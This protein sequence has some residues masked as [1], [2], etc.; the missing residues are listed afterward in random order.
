MGNGSHRA[1]AIKEDFH[2]NDLKLKIQRV[3]SMKSGHTQD[4]KPKT[5][6]RRIKYS[7][8]LAVDDTELLKA[9]RSQEDLG[10]S[11]GKSVANV[12]K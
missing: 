3:D 6:E 5:S 12:R 7:G 1:S 8:K 2:D 4:S 9:F 10:S 11:T